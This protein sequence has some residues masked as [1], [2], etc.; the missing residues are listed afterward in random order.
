MPPT[1]GL[2]KVCVGIPSARMISGG[3]YFCHQPLSWI[4]VL[5][6]AG[7]WTTVNVNILTTISRVLPSAMQLL[8]PT[9]FRLQILR[10]FDAHVIEQ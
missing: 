9:T 6:A 8:T 5:R 2:C 4:G 3:A 1:C 7:F 10:S